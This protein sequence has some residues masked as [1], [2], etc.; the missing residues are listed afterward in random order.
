MV[1]AH[2]K[3]DTSLAYSIALKVHF[4]AQMLHYQMGFESEDRAKTTAWS[5][6]SKLAM[7]Q[8][9]SLSDNPCSQLLA[10][11]VKMASQ[12]RWLENFQ[13]IDAKIGI[14]QAQCTNAD[15]QSVSAD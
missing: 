8:Y 7:R 14:M 9:A 6:Q 13:S 3:G 2:Q 15:F 1:M 12:P 10:D 11:I 4:A 5:L